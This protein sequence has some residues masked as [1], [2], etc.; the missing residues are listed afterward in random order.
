[1][2]VAGSNPVFRSSS[3]PFRSGSDGGIG[4]HVGLKIQWTAMSVRVQ[5][6]LRVLMRKDQVDKPGFFVS[7]KAVKL[8]FKGLEE[9]KNTD[10]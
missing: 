1:M 9:T 4:R 5:V 3:T 8:A 7:E 6:P 10:A 2:R